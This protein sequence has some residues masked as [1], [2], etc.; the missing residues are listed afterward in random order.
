MEKINDRKEAKLQLEGA[1][2]EQ[3]KERRSE[4]YNV[5]NKNVKWSTRKG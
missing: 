2:S 3:L 1:S 4:E 5:K